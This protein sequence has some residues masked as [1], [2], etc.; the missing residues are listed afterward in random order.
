MASLARARVVCGVFRGVGGTTDSE[1]VML[2]GDASFSLQLAMM[3]TVCGDGTEHRL[4]QKVLATLPSA[5]V[6]RN[7]VEVYQI[8][9]A[10]NWSNA[11]KLA[12]VQAHAKHLMVMRGLVLL[13][14]GVAPDR[15]FQ[16]RGMAPLVT[17]I[18]MFANCRV[19]DKALVGRPRSARGLRVGEGKA[20]MKGRTATEKYCELLKF[21]DFFVPQDNHG[22][23]EHDC[24]H[25]VQ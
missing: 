5:T 7:I 1:R 9:H 20:G 4:A 23:R 13:G 3:S 17:R 12:T 25:C 24:R 11:Y 16:G 19:G 2:M 14:D 8:V 22:G 10:V 6:H 21:F 15:A 18:G